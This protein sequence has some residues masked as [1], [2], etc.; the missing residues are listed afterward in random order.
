MPLV[1]EPIYSSGESRYLPGDDHLPTVRER[2]ARYDR[3]MMAAADAVRRDPSDENKKTLDRAIKKVVGEKDHATA[4]LHHRAHALANRE[5][6]NWALDW[7]E[8]HG[9]ALRA[10]GPWRYAPIEC[11]VLADR[12]AVC[13]F[14]NAAG[15]T[16]FEAI[17]T[18]RI[19]CYDWA[20]L[21]DAQIGLLPGGKIREALVEAL[22]PEGDPALPRM[23]G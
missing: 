6:T 20:A 11:A 17:P 1:K 7:I 12:G 13:G 8:A 4:L 16:V 22:R 3:E 5:P 2:L 21:L 15:Q 14:L 10:L 23:A 9:P 18:A 19:P